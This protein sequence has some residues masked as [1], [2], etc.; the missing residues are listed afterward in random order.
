MVKKKIVKNCKH[1][2]I[3]IVGGF[4]SNKVYCDP[5]LKCLEALRNEDYYYGK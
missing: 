4:A 1:N 3:N 5:L 2:F